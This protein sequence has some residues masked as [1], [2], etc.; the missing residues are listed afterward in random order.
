MFLAGRMFIYR[1]DPTERICGVW[2]TFL[3]MGLNALR[4]IQWGAFVLST[5]GEWTEQLIMIFG[6]STAAIVIWA[7]LCYNVG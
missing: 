2:Q 4:L 6:L 3:M 7:S 1:D 5:Q